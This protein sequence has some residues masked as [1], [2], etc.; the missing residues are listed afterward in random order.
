MNYINLTPHAIVLNDGRIYEP[1]GSIARVSSSFSAVVDDVCQQV[2]GEIQ[3]L[4]EPQVGVRLIVSGMVLSAL[5][6]TRKDVVAP[7]TGH[8]DTQRN[9][10][11][12]IIS[13]PCFTR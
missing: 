10:K 9:D 6:D 2:F 12:H 3:D 4:P 7:A 5:K 1:S 13:V 8:P 11:G